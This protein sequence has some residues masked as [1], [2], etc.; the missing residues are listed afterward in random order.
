M[1]A[2]AKGLLHHMQSLLCSGCGLARVIKRVWVTREQCQHKSGRT[3]EVLCDECALLRGDCQM[4]LVDQLIA[5]AEKYQPKRV[6]R[7]KK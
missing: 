1:F 7:C 6:K 5:I 4:L 2:P 3:V